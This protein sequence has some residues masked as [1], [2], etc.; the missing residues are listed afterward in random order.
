MGHDSFVDRH[1]HLHR[2][3]YGALDDNRKKKR[4]IFV[5]G[6]TFV[7]EEG[8]RRAVELGIAPVHKWI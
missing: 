8:D 1:F 3:L 5:E 6:C 7:G 2:H 4:R